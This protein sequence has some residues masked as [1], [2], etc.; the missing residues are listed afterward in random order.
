LAALGYPD[1]LLAARQQARM[2]L[3]GRLSRYQ[4][5]IQQFERK[6]GCTL[7]EMEVRYK[8]EGQETFEVDDDYLD[9]RWYADAADIV[10]AQLMA[11]AAH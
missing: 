11:I 8:M 10:Q 9:W 4:A 7:D 5:L 3:L 1:P 2:L 6:W